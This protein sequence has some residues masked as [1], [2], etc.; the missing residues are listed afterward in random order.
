MK[1]DCFYESSVTDAN[2]L[3]EIRAGDS[4]AMTVIFDRY[5]SF[6]FGV[7]LRVLK[8][9]EDAEDVMQEIFMQLWRRSER[10]AIERGH[11]RTWLGVVTRHRAI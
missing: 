6:V 3:V 9:R 11:L 7:A 8:N 5:S 10:Y 1:S 2:L 4:Q